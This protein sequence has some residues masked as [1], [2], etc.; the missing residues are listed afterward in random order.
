VGNLVKMF[1]KASSVVFFLAIIILYQNCGSSPQGANPQ[2]STVHKLGDSVSTAGATEFNIR[3][4]M[5]GGSSFDHR[6]FDAS[7]E[8]D[9]F[10]ISPSLSNAIASNKKFVV[11]VI[12]GK[13]S[14]SVTLQFNNHNIS[15][16]DYQSMVDQYL[17]S[18]ALIPSYQLAG[19]VDNLTT[20]KVIV[21]KTANAFNI[22]SSRDDQVKVGE[23]NINKEYCDGA[24][25]IQIVDPSEMV[26]DSNT[27]IVTSGVLFEMAIYAL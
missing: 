3:W 5:N 1:A 16:G 17:K 27:G 25:V 12:N 21:P 18:A 26:I 11:L 20:F 15:A 10:N 8:I 13:S 23:F 2:D 7:N 19:S 4:W 22:R 24:L 6:G 14:P 9:L